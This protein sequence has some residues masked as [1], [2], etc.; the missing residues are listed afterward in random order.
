MKFSCLALRVG[1]V[2]SSTLLLITLISYTKTG[3][4]LDIYESQ[5]TAILGHSGAGKSSLLN[6]L[7]GLYV[8]TA[9]KRKAIPHRQDTC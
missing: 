8:P 3:L 5:I 2:L 4:F 1:L 7:S 9:G 6:I